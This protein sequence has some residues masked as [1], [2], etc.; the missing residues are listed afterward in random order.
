VVDG[1]VACAGEGL[2]EGVAG[3]GAGVPVAAFVFIEGVADASVVAVSCG[4][5]DLETFGDVAEEDE[6]GGDLVFDAGPDLIG[7]DEGEG[8]C[9]AFG[10]GAEEQAGFGAAGVAWALGIGMGGQVM[11]EIVAVDGAEV[12]GDFLGVEDLTDTADEGEPG[13]EDTV[14]EAAIAV[15]VFGAFLFEECACFGGV[16]ADHAADLDRVFGLQPFPLDLLDEVF[17][18]EQFGFHALESGLEELG[19]ERGGVVEGLGHVDGGGEGAEVEAGAHAIGTPELDVV[20]VMVGFF[21]PAAV[22]GIPRADA[23]IEAGFDLGPELSEPLG[24]TTDAP[25]PVDLHDTAELSIG[26]GVEVMGDG[27]DGE[28]AAE[29]LVAVFILGWAELGFAER[30]F[31]AGE[32]VWEC[33]GVVP[34]VG[35]GAV[36]AAAIVGAAFPTPE[37]AVGLA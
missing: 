11:F 20:G 1:V 4:A 10:P 25:F 3:H 23:V 19:V 24:V 34:D 2:E 27:A 14:G 5:H 13:A 21:E 29:L 22:L 36:A 31:Q 16:G 8:E 7:I 35:A 33:L 9:A 28:G 18:V 17:A 37:P 12:A 26:G 6:V 30:S 15:L 32:E